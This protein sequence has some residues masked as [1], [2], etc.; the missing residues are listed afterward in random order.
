MAISK[1]G[2]PIFE[3]PMSVEQIGGMN[4][5]S[6]LFSGLMSA[7]NAYSIEATGKIIGDIKFGNI[8]S[9]FSKDGFDN[10][11]VVLTH[12]DISNELLK[13]IHIEIKSLFLNS[14]EQI[15]VDIDP[16]KV[17]NIE[18]TINN[19]ERIESIFDPFYRMWIKKIMHLST[20]S[21]K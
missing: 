2:V 5:N 14:L 1:V 15:K 8:Q 3:Y 13:Q 17:Y 16:E 12:E 4:I 9:T 10:L 21:Y 7:I 20:P 18:K 19:K 6:V 11:Y